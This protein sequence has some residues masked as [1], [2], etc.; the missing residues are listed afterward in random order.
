MAI[1]SINPATGETLCE[2]D[3]LTNEEIEQ[4]LAAAETAFRKHRVTSNAAR[5]AILST[6]ADLLEA[7]V[8]DLAGIITLEMGKPIGA[9]RA[10]VKKCA[11]GCRYYAENAGRF[12]EEE[13]IQ[14]A[15]AHSA[16]RGRP[17]E[18]R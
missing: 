1:A 4:K 13:V 11:G 2:F 7:E 16:V 15:A 18:A 5:A 12:L 6:A 9:A 8:D 3:S 10:E 17:I 14:T